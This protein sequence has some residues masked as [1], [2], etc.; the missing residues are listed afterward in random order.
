MDR[1]GFEVTPPA[2]LPTVA[3][4]FTL[5]AFRFP[6][7]EEHLAVIK[8]DPSGPNTLARI[9]SSCLT[10]DVLGSR[11]CDCGPQLAA[12]LEAIER[13]GRG[14]VLYL[15]QEGR[16]IGL[17][18]KIRA[19]VE[20]DAGANTVEAN[21]KLGFDADE[22]NYEQAAAMLAHL[23]VASVRLLTNNPKKVEALE[24]AGIPVAERVPH[25]V[26]ANDANRLYIATKRDLLGHIIG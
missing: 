22:R 12:A 8:G 25:V 5:V 4:A 19:Y 16:G 2:E 9:H 26:G 1:P 24:A 10:G 14:V 6:D 3:G 7:G 11:R 15:N 23:G 13:E 20:Q 21:L 18:N 17:F